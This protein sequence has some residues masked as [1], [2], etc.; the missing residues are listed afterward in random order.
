VHTNDIHGGLV[1]SDAFWLSPDFPP[2][3]GNAPAAMTVI[4]ELRE[5][6]RKDGYG[7]LYFDTGDLFSG[8]PVGEFSHG[9]AVVDFL[10]AAGCDLCVP[11]NHDFDQGLDVFLDLVKRSNAPFLA[12]NIVKQGTDSLWNGVLADTVFERAGVKL[13]VFGLLTHYMKGTATE[14]S[15]GGLDVVKHYVAAQRSIADLKAKGADI[16]IGAT[17]I[18][19]SH[20]RNLADSIPG[21]DVIIGGHS[22]TGLREP[23]EFNRYHTIVAQTYGRL[24]SVGLLDLVVDM[25]TK[26][27]ASYS[28]NLIELSADE[29]VMDTL[30]LRL[31]DE[32]RVKAE[33]GFDV[34]IGSAKRNITRGGNEE[35]AMGNL[36]ADALREPFG[37]DIAVH[38]GVRG[39]LN[40]GDVTYRDVYQ[41]DPFGNTV[42]TMTMTGKQVWEMLEISINGH[43]AIFQVSG[44]K[45]VYDPRKPIGKRISSVLIGGKP[46]EPDKTYKVVTNNYLAAGSGEYAIFTQG[47]EI[48]DTFT[49]VRDAMV[50]YIRKHSPVDAR[51]EGRIV[52]E[53]R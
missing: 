10:K 23:G 5:Q 3:I 46:I 52:T 33:S 20:D 37:G 53:S 42:V 15:F 29:I 12:A 19:Y 2:P 13:G 16:I 11:G 8:T 6:A 26:R 25:E 24:T 35:S 28:G 47:M 22:H 17:H 31:V 49:P 40:Q 32:W 4:R 41:A 30:E 36:M 43:H 21:I 9:Q 45:M 34:V 51:I 50:D 1:P 38:S 27:I 7:F 39:G 14:K 18:G 48:E 44:L